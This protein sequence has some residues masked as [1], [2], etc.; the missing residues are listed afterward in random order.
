MWK[1][2]ETTNWVLQTDIGELV[3]FRRLGEA[4]TS[5]AITDLVPT[6]YE[7]VN[8]VGKTMDRH[9][10]TCDGVRVIV[11]ANGVDV[12]EDK[13]CYGLCASDL[14]DIVRGAESNGELVMKDVEHARLAIVQRDDHIR[15]EITSKYSEK[16]S[17]IKK[18]KTS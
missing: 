7:C 5:G 6:F 8:G 1:S 16:G 4:R 10:F 9:F 12:H 18:A 3:T 17:A 15:I 11:S 2:T 14:A 13:E